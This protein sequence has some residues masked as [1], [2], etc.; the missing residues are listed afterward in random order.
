M[1]RKTKRI[2]LVLTMILAIL[3]LGSSLLAQGINPCIQRKYFGYAIGEE[4]GFGSLHAIEGDRLIISVLHP[5]YRVLVEYDAQSDQWL[6]STTFE[7]PI[8]HSSGGFGRITVDMHGDLLILGG[9]NSYLGTGAALVYRYDPGLDTWAG[10]GLLV[11]SDAEQGA[12][13]G[14]AVAIG[15]STILIGS[16]NK[17][18]DGCVGDPLDCD[19]FGVA[20]VYTHDGTGWVEEAILEA[21]DG[22]SFDYFGSNVALYGETAIVSARVGYTGSAN[23]G[24][25]YIFKRYGGL[26]PQVAKIIAPEGHLQEQGFGY[27][28]DYDGTTLAVGA[29]EHEYE[30]SDRGAVYLF[31]DD[32]TPTWDYQGKLTPPYHPDGLNDGFGD[33]L[34]IDGDRLA[35]ASNTFSSKN[36][37]HT[38][39]KI[40]GSW[41]HW[42]RY[43]ALDGPLLGDLFGTSIAIHRDRLLVGA[44]GDDEIDFDA[45][46]IY[47]HALAFQSDCNVN[48]IEDGEDIANGTG[49]DCNADGVMDECEILDGTAVDCN[50]NLIPDDCED[51]NDNGQADECELAGQWITQSPQLG[52]IGLGSSPTHTFFAPR[53]A[54]TDVTLDLSAIADL[55]GSFKYI[56]V[57]LNDDYQ[58][59]VFNDVNTLGCLPVPEYDQLVIP[60]ADYNALVGSGDAIFSFVGDGFLTDTCVDLAWVQFTMSYTGPPTTPDVNVNGVPDSCDL[61]RGDNNLDGVVN[62]DDLLS[63]LAKWGA[64]GSPC[65]EDTDLDGNVDVEDLL[66]LLAGWG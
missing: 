5:S 10:E 1:I 63:L 15:P 48:C 39:R 53:T 12:D 31:R 21:S 40:D 32:G 24:A 42:N 51:C 66:S 16:P 27:A 6:Y 18:K 25:I 38:Y 61:A 26:W 37:A 55:N 36:A 56:E 7:T 9:S 45:G 2:H 49:F 54:L 57:Y 28:L 20:Y 59:R 62:V 33:M 8:L 22:L 46:A 30:G 34:L 65:P 47:S 35:V 17:N 52:P 29:D 13:F 14:S 60:M 3:G 50:N 58:G 64:C 43:I 11:A 41:V 19:N 44:P 4:V 23:Y